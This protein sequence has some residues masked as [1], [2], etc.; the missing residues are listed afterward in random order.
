MHAILI[1]LAAVTFPEMLYKV[2]LPGAGDQESWLLSVDFEETPTE[3]LTFVLASKGEEAGR[4]VIRDPQLMDEDGDGFIRF[5]FHRPRALGVDR[6]T[7]FTGERK[8]AD[9]PLATYEQKNSYIFPLTGNGLITQGLFNQ[10][11]HAGRSTRF[12]NDVI[13]LGDSFAPQTAPESSNETMSGWGRPV[14][15]AADGRVVFVQTGIPDQEYG[16]YDEPGFTLE[17]GTVAHWGNA[18]VIDHGKGEFMALMHLREGSVTVKAG[19]QVKQGDRIGALGNSGDSFGPHLH[20]QLQNGPR[21]DGDNGLPVKFS[22][23]YAD[24]YLHKGDWI[25]RVP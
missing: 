4:E 15:A 17:D 1:A 11:G 16:V 25:V 12:A 8:M 6:L 18:V 10:G 5:A 9:I 21:P 13:G 24:R 20:I 23:Q 3:P 22:D 2:P 19:D 14:V 7:V